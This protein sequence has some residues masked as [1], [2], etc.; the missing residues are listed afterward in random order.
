M[1]N[2]KT[3]VWKVL[4]ETNYSSEDAAE[5][6]SMILNNMSFNEKAAAKVLAN[7]HPTLQQNAMRLV[8]AFISEMAQKDYSDDRNEASVK[9]AQRVDQEMCRDDGGFYRAYFPH[10]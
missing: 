5:I 8:V 3:Q 2:V 4:R 6:I 1:E 7:Q 9:F 10:V